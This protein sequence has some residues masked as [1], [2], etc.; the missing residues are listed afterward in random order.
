MHPRSR[1][2]PAAGTLVHFHGRGH[3]AAHKALQNAY[4]N[5]RDFVFPHGDR[6]TRFSSSRLRLSNMSLFRNVTSG[7][8]C[9]AD[10]TDTVRITLPAAGTVE[11]VTP[12]R[13]PVVAIAALKGSVCLSEAVGR[14]VPS[15]YKGFHFAISKDHLL[16]R[17]QL[18][19][20][21]R[22]SEAEI[23]PSVDLRTLEGASLYRNIANA[24]FEVEHLTAN[25]FGPLAQVLANDL[26]VNLAAVA[27]LRGMREQLTQR[28]PSV[29]ANAIETARQFI[30]AH[31]AE[32]I[33]LNEL[34]S[35][36][37][38]SSRALQQGF[39]RRFGCTPSEHLFACRLG[40][41]RTRLLSPTD[42]TRVATVA[43]EC[44][45]VNV[46]AFAARYRSVFGEQP[47]QTLK[48]AKS[49]R[50]TQ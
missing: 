6:V 1:S 14:N 3:E 18:L 17:A 12:T 46:G 47:S 43:V 37:G 2:I 27:I 41:A 23:A 7:Y 13:A 29:G 16:A 44:G 45:F 38:V 9:R 42:Q 19:T 31:A 50:R 4:P 20:G 40:L 48:M 32:P 26:I 22:F 36:L 10:P 35:H 33:S 28:Q 8:A 25:G 30:D 5:A 15:D 24:F 11:V 49:I 39:R 21:R 34:A